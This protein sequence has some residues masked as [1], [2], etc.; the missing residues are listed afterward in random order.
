M[1]SIYE[2]RI[3]PDAN[4]IHS[5]NCILVVIPEYFVSKLTRLFSQPIIVRESNVYILYV[6]VWYDVCVTNER[7]YNV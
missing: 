2:N 7:L 4:H 3:M 5:R 1:K 6:K